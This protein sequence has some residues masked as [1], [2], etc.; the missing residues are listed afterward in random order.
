MLKALRLGLYS[1]L[2]MLVLGV[3]GVQVLRWTA[4]DDSEQAL[5]ALARVAPAPAEGRNGYAALALSGYDIPADAIDG[6]MAAEVQGY[7]T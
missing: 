2:G 5:L 3:L 7:T 1:L 6:Q 4:L